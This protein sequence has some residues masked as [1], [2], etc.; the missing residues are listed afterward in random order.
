M[1]VVCINRLA[2]FQRG[3][4]RTIELFYVKS[5]LVKDRV[6]CYRLV[7]EIFMKSFGGCEN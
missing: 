2:E 6:H 3:N 5:G 1:V 4:S 7:V